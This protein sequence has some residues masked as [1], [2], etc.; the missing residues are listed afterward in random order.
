MGELSMNTN[1]RI[2]LE[3]LVLER[4]LSFHDPNYECPRNDEKNCHLS[5]INS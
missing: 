1:R 5:L 3:E 4:I 2:V